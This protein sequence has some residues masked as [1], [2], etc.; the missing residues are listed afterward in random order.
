V[1]AASQPD[2]DAPDPAKRLEAAQAVFKSRDASA[3]P[4]LD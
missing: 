3:L 4:A 2:P 1:Q